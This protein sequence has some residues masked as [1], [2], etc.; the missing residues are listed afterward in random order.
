M[1]YETELERSEAVDREKH[2]AKDIAKLAINTGNMVISLANIDIALEGRARP[3]VTESAARRTGEGGSMSYA[4]SL[5]RAFPPGSR[6]EVS[7]VRESR[8]NGVYIGMVEVVT[9][10]C[11]VLGEAPET[12][13]HLRHVVSVKRYR[14]A[15]AN[16]P[17][18]WKGPQATL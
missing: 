9:D 17:T 3:R 15:P 5:S 4:D 13:I 11:L 10:D 6:V 2:M 18:T 16:E 8:P 7:V 12:Y 1:N 14:P